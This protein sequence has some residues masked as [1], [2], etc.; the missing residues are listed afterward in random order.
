M[1]WAPNKMVTTV[2]MT[3]SMDFLERKVLYLD[4]S[5]TEI[6]NWASNWK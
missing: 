4:E 3:L 1:L 5:F 2:Q 6:C